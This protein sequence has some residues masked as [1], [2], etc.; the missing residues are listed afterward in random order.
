MSKWVKRWKYSLSAKPVMP[1]VWRR[2]E[3]GFLVRGRATDPRTGKQRE[4]MRALDGDDPAVAFASL[5]AELRTVREGPTPSAPPRFDEFAASLMARKIREGTI[6][7]AAGRERWANHLEH[8]LLPTF[9]ALRVDQIRRADV[10]RWRDE[11]AAGVAAGR[12]SPRTV[13]D[14]L[15]LLRVILNAAVAEFELARNPVTG[16]P[17]LPTVLHPAY[18]DEEPN[19][20]TA[21]EARRFMAAV[22]ETSPNEFAMIALGFATGLRPSTLRPLRRQGPE[23]DLDLARGILRV[24][25]SHTRGQEVMPCTKTGTRGRITLPPELVDILRWHID[26][27][28]EGPARESDLLFPSPEGLIRSRECLTWPMERARRR[29][30]ITKHLSPR[31]M[32]RSFQDFAREAEVAGI[33]ARSISGHATEEMQDHYSTVSGREQQ[34]GL[35]RVVSLA[36]FREAL[37]GGKGGGKLDPPAGTPAEPVT[38][39]VGTAQGSGERPRR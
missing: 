11:G 6:R 27:I 28:P 31:A 1:G 3:G 30:G 2:E 8:H 4:V 23:A 12:Y 13:N 29:A 15:A 39:P 18:T 9:G 20:V 35:A 33:V 22:R 32:R 37:G 10:M 24:R 25:R 21:E 26:R 16:V 17:P 19:S 36:G 34:E 14:W 7:S 38:Q 5:H